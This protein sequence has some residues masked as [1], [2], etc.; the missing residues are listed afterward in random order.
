[1]AY[2]MADIW[3]IFKRKFLDL[4]KRNV[5]PALVMFRKPTPTDEEVDALALRLS[6]LHK[7][8]QSI[9][10]FLRKHASVFRDLM[11]DDWSWSGIAMAMTKAGIMYETKTEWSGTVL[12]KTF[13]RA[14][15]PLKGKQTNSRSDPESRMIQNEVPVEA[16]SLSLPSSPSTKSIFSRPEAAHDIARS[17]GSEPIFQNET[18]PKFRAFSVKAQ[19]PPR[20]PTAEEIR[21]REA[22]RIRMFGKS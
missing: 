12:M 21:E 3:H 10:P 13:W 5:E 19:E 20:E 1:M 17:G 22:I 4:D 9:R 7:R 14:Q 2:R 15:L 6:M 8:G 11:N 16:D 18:S